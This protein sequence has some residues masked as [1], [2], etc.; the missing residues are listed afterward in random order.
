MAG[1]LT[2]LSRAQG[3]LWGGEDAPEQRGLAAGS[4]HAH[5][6]TTM[7]TFESVHESRIV[8]KL[9]AVDRLI[10]KM[11]R[12]YEVEGKL[13][14]KWVS[15]NKGVANLKRFFEVA[16]ASN[17]AALRDLGRGDSQ[18]V[19]VAFI[20]ALDDLSRPHTSWSFARQSL[21]MRRERHEYC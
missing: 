17:G 14:G 5:L 13:V 1:R 20:Q 4:P 9:V 10:F 7:T 2:L 3:C 8:G 18:G 6:G 19:E 12:Y 15:M 16:S 11:L 21:T